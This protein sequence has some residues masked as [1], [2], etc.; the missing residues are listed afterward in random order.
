M[1]GRVSSVYYQALMMKKIG[2][3]I[4]ISESQ[5]VTM[6][7]F[8]L[9]TKNNGADTLTDEKIITCPFNKNNVATVKNK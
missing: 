5:F 3:S 1:F 4:T 9:L 2:T 7:I 6:V 8:S